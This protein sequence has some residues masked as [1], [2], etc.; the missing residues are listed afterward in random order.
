MKLVFGKGYNDLKEDGSQS[1]FYRTWVSM[2]ERCY[3]IKRQ[4]K[5]PTYVGCSVCEDWLTFSKFKTWME[6]QDWEGKQLD[7]DIL[8]PGNK[9]YSP[10]A[11]VFVSQELN[12]FFIESN[13]S[14]GLYPIGVDFHKPSKKFRSRCRVNGIK[15]HLGY[16]DTSE[17]AFNAWK[18]KKLELA[19]F[20]ASQQK[21]IRIAKAIT[22]RYEKY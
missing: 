20:Y 22:E 6:T 4:I 12:K 7:K 3:S 17:E 19:R 9:V 10:D 8:V 2:L 18:N 13:A 5:Q 21:D 14:R 16:F 1:K 11:C 15:M